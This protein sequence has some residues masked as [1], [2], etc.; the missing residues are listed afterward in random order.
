MKTN[1]KNIGVSPFLLVILSFLLVIF[2]G[3]FLLTTPLASSNGQWSN[4]VDALFTAVSATCVTGLS[5]YRNGI[6]G[7][8]TVFGQIVVLICIQIGGLGFMTILAFIITLFRHKLQF[9]DRYLLSQ[10]VG[11]ASMSDLVIFVRKIILIS[12]SFEIIGTALL[13]PVFLQVTDVQHSLWF[14][15]FHSVS[16]YNNAGF[17][18]FGTVS[19]VLGNSGI[20]SSLPQW[21]YIYLCITTMLLIVL[22]GISFLTVI[23]V[24]H[25][26]KPSQ[27]RAFT[28]IV[29]LTT[30]ILIFGGAALFMLTEGT[31]ATNRMDVL[32]AFFQSITLRTAGFATY[33]QANL[34][35]AGK[36]ISCILMFIG[37]SPL[38]TAGGVKTTTFFMI[39]LAMTAYFRGRKIVAFKR[40]YS[41]G[42]VIKAMSLVFTAIFIIL[43]AYLIVSGFESNNPMLD[44]ERQSLIYEVFSAF[45]TVGVSTGITP[46]LSVGSK[47][48]L[49]VL[50][51]IGRLGPI[52][53]MQIFQRNLDVKEKYHFQYVEED[54]LIG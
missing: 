52:S 51:F 42:M 19:L 16:A 35:V 23:D 38:S 43:G 14:S 41:N 18:V 22:G 46:Y 47:I 25:F 5:V 53:F 54:F 4:F 48:T 45:G 32:Q 49:C 26:R 1:K 31:K 15:V 11:S 37:G 3:A 2:L 10:A 9:K 20:I 33:D 8:L 40:Y 44:D 7:D 24:F 21:A 30:F 28:K 39:I 17:D 29:L 50:M 36:V 34:S 27:W 13:L 12:F 6:A